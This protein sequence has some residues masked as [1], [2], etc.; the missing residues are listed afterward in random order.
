VTTFAAAP[1]PA[2]KS[3]LALS[4]AE[5]RDLLWGA[6]NDGFRDNLGLIAA[7]VA[8]FALMALFPA[9][10]ALVAVYGLVG[11]PTGV[12]KQI[13]ALVGIAPAP[14]IQIARE[15]LDRLVNARTDIL[16]LHGLVSLVIALW[17]A[18][19]GTRSFL[20]ALTIINERTR[21]RRFFRRYLVGGAFTLGAVA[22]AAITVFLFALAPNLF[23]QLGANVEF[24]LDL[25]RWPVLVALVTAFAMALYRW[26]PNRKAPRWAWV[27][28]GALMAS[29][30]WLLVS[31]GFTLY[32]DVFTPLRAAYGVFSGVFVLMLWLF[33]SA[34]IF[35]LGAEINARLEQVCAIEGGACVTLPPKPRADNLSTPDPLGGAGP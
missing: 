21:R 29:V 25:L 14:V 6:W 7:G 22:V 1:L 5:W 3:P 35:L 26:G 20:R 28:P 16:A 23:A 8:F 12:A 32:V 30:A 15:Q 11:D 18:Q 4:I 24:T 2:P 13:D 27:W 31:A 9:L 34:Y 10:S 17:S 33:L 19:Q